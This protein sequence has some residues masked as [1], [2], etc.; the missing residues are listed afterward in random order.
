VVATNGDHVTKV[1][2]PAVFVI[3]LR[4]YFSIHIGIEMELIVYISATFLRA[5]LSMTHR[6]R[7]DITIIK[8]A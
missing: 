1:H 8:I 3:P 6:N 7:L 5:I 4:Q 2:V